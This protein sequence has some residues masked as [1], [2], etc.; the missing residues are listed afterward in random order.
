MNSSVPR[1][2][3]TLTDVLG[4]ARTA[5]VPTPAPAGA[6]AA[7]APAASTPATARTRD[8]ELL[9]AELVHRVLQRVDM[10]LA[11]RLTAAVTAVIAQRT[12]EMLP[13]LREEIA[14]AVRLSVTD[15]VSQELHH[16]ELDEPERGA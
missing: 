10:M 8:T 14:E 3:P 12:R 2:V 6:S 13:Q 5:P 7:T 11:D 9:E 15:A 16:A 4:S 1:F